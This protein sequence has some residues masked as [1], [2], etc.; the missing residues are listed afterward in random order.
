MVAT[1]GLGDV[2]LIIDGGPATVL[3]GIGGGSVQSVVPS[4]NIK[5]LIGILLLVFRV[6][7]KI[8]LYV[9]RVLTSQLVAFHVNVQL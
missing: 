7:R 3:L 8:D 1:P 9:I 2:G 5:N 6:F 4:V